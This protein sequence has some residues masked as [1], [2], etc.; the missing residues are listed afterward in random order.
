MVLK[1]SR[2]RTFAQDGMTVSHINEGLTAGHL[3][4]AL[5]TGHLAQALGS[6][7]ATTNQSTAPQ[8]ATAPATGNV[9]PSVSIPQ[10]E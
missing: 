8:P 5:T 4:K 1:I 6:S 7:T 2:P 3:G 9:S 10:K